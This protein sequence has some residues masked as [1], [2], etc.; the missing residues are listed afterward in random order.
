MIFLDI[1]GNPLGKGSSLRDCISFAFQ[2]SPKE[3][4]LSSKMNY[5]WD[6]LETHKLGSQLTTV[7]FLD[8]SLRVVFFPH[9]LIWIPFR[10][11]RFIRVVVFLVCFL[12]S[13]HKSYEE[14]VCRSCVWIL[15]LV[16]VFFLPPIVDFS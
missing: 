12:N 7:R 5:R 13:R 14:L 2:K 6:A 3:V 10:S 9:H 1:S 11:F 4:F 8:S 16:C 15:L